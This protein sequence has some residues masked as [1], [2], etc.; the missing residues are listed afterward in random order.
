MLKVIL[1][2]LMS[3][4]SIWFQQQISKVIRSSQNEL[5]ISSEIISTVSPL[6]S[7]QV[8]LLLQAI[9]EPQLVLHLNIQQRD[10]HACTHVHNPLQSFA[11]SLTFLT[12]TDAHITSSVSLSLSLPP[13][14]VHRHTHTHTHSPPVSGGEMTVSVLP[15]V[16]SAVSVTPN[17]DLLSAAPQGI[18]PQSRSKHLFSHLSSPLQL[19][20]PLSTFMDRDNILLTAIFTAVVSQTQFAD[21][22]SSF[23]LTIVVC[24]L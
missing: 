3:C 8:L 10:A 7:S 15:G 18:Q 9:S 21:F 22:L 19:L 4:P 23:K 11:F 1:H 16:L 17:R 12:D 13:G 24:K 14:H 6:L 20:S 2:F 5:F